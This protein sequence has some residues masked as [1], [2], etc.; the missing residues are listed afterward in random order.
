MKKKI[1]T[2]LVCMAAMVIGYSQEASV[3]VMRYE[4]ELTYSPDSLRSDYKEKEYFYLDIHNAKSRFASTGYVRKFELSHGSQKENIA[5][6]SGLIAEMRTKFNWVIYKNQNELH[7]YETQFLDTYWVEESLA[8]VVW[9]ILPEREEYHD[10]KVQKAVTTFG[11][12]KWYVYFTPDIKVY[13]GPYKFKNLPGFVVK[14]WDDR[15]HYVFEFLNSKAVK[16]L[17]DEDLIR[18][19]Q[20]LKVSK[21]KLFALREENASKPLEARLPAGITIERVDNGGQAPKKPRKK[22][23]NPIEF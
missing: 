19:E 8:D 13:D 14:A 12:R 9:E 10:F 4:Y 15:E 21:Q 23:A 7:T 11:G 6:M 17:F 22:T 5:L 18:E 16:T 1:Y 2:L 3:E 20:P